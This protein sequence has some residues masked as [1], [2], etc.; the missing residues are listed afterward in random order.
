MRDN[1]IDIKLSIP[2]EAAGKRLDQALSQL[3]P[4]YSRARIQ[5]WIL[6]GNVLLDGSKCRPK[7]KV[8][9]NEQ[10]EIQLE[11]QPEGEWLPQDIPIDVVYADD[12]IIV[13]NKPIGLVVHPGAGVPDGTLVNALLH[14]DKNLEKL[15]RAGIV[16]RLDKDTSGLLV[17]ARSIKAH[18]SLIGQLQTKS[19]QREYDAIVNGEMISGGTVNANIGRNPKNRLKM[20]V[21]EGG[22]PAVTHYRVKEKFAKYTYIHCQLETGRTHQIRVHMAHIG[23]PLLGDA[24]YGIRG[25][26]LKQKLRRQALHAVRLTLKHPANGEEMTFEAPLPK[27]MQEILE[28]LRHDQS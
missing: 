28:I 20:A 11:L 2:P 26:S 8:K 3:L 13:V 7:D 14:Y 9:G 5:D 15:P 24:L 22:K 4:D 1:N 16:H 17:V 27:D 18:T 21:V 25:D 6:Q 12:D 10:V 19:M 23:H